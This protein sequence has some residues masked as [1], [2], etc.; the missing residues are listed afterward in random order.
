MKLGSTCH[1]DSGGPLFVQINKVN[2]LAGVT[3]AGGKNCQ[4]GSQTYDFDV[5]KFRKWIRGHLMENPPNSG[6]AP[7]VQHIS[8][9]GCKLCKSCDTSPKKAA[10][11]IE[12]VIPKRNANR[13]LVTMN[14]TVGTVPY[15]LSLTPSGGQPK[16]KCGAKSA[17]AVR[18]C[19]EVSVSAGQKFEVEIAGAASRECQI[20]AT[21]FVR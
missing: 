12:I 4:P 16:V 3:S 10:T 15:E 21:T 2:H 1:G 17:S 11:K 13:L 7:A 19:S 20:V 6:S 14:C 9:L 18:Q 5:F 8:Q